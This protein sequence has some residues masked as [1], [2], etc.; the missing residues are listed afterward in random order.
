VR[1]PSTFSLEIT[2]AKPTNYKG[3]KRAKELARLEKK[4]EKRKR[5][6]HKDEA[7]LPLTDDISRTSEE[8]VYT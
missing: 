4:E 2:V 7:A 8:E 3:E 6:Q 1:G 5:K